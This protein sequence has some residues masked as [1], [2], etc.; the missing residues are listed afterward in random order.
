FEEKSIHYAIKSLASYEGKK[1]LISGGGNSAIDWA[2]ELESIADNVTLIYR[3]DQFTGIESNITRLMN[4]SVEVLNPYKI[5]ELKEE[6]DK[7]STVVMEHV[8]TKARKEIEVDYL[9]VTHGFHINLGPI[10][11]WGMTMEEGT[12]QVDATMSTSIPGIYAVGDI[13][14]Y[15]NKLGLIAGG[16]NEGPIAV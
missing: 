13:S 6:Q 14:N 16:F 5:V 2:H 7:L 4:S 12:I 10:A 8:G 1:V 9:I 11:D 15:P 3:K